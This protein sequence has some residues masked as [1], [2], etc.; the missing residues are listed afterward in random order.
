[1]SR[2]TGIELL[3]R[4][5]KHTLVVRTRT[6]VEKLPEV[7]RTSYAQIAAYLKELDV[8]MADVP[9]VA[10]YNMDMED[11][12]VEIGFVVPRQ[13]P[14]KNNIQAGIIAAGKAA[15]CM[16][17]GPYMDIEPVYMDILKWMF[18]HEYEP[19]GV[20]YEHYYNS[21]E[22]FPESELLTRIVMPIK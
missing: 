22:D 2:V 9:F 10:Y 16:H 12:D 14:G 17:K 3:E 13:L 1:M 11:L 15:L 4:A 19:T 18:D 7:I 8:M 6:N 21:P 20:V 5:Q